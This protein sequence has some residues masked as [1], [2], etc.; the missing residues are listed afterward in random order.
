MGTLPPPADVLWQVA[1]LLARVVVL[2]EALAD[3]YFTLAAAVAERLELDLVA[4]R[5]RLEGEKA[6]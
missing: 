4:L 6:A 1:D 3:G 5:E 2:R